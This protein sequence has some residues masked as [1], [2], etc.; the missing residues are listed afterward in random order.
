MSEGLGR[1][2]GSRHRG[3]APPLIAQRT[4]R[5]KW[6]PPSEPRPRWPFGGAFFACWA[7]SGDIPDGAPTTVG[8]RTCHSARSR[9]RRA[10]GSGYAPSCRHSRSDR[11]LIRRRVVPGPVHSKVNPSFERFVGLT[12]I[13]RSLRD[14]YDALAPPMPGY[15]AALVEQLK[16]E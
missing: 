4:K 1:R 12:A 9:R 5:G 8:N 16:T 2:G 6:L 10:R 7:R 3:T 15:L 13:A 11:L 14:R